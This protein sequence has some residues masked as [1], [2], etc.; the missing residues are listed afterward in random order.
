MISNLELSIVGHWGISDFIVSEGY[1]KQGSAECVWCSKV[2]GVGEFVMLVKEDGHAAAFAMHPKCLPLSQSS[3]LDG[4]R[5]RSSRA[6]PA[7]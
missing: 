3:S 6:R 5:F 7:E 4:S 1:V 2:A